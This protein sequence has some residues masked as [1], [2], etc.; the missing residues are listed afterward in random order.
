M[1][2]R[3]GD[4]DDF[5]RL[6]QHG[7]RTRHGTLWMTW[8]TDVTA[9]PPRVGYSV[10][11]SLGR[12]ATRNHVRRRIRSIVREIAR[13]GWLPNGLYLIG[14]RPGTERLPF[15]DVAAGV[16]HLVR[17]AATAQASAKAAVPA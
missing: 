5:H 9:S 12:A 4:R 11:R 10:G 3:L 17:A 1:I 8:V 16:R 14:A 2:W 7:R 15:T 13:E 6:Q